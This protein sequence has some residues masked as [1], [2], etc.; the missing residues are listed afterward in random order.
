MVALIRFLINRTAIL[1]MLGSPASH[2]A[3]QKEFP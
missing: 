1:S 2:P 3:D